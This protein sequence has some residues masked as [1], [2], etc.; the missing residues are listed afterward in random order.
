MTSLLLF[1]AAGTLALRM[2]GPALSV[3]PVQ[4]S[5]LLM[6]ESPVEDLTTLKARRKELKP[7]LEAKEAEGANFLQMKM[8]LT[9][10]NERNDATLAEV[11]TSGWLGWRWG[12]GV[13]RWSASSALCH[14]TIAPS[15]MALTCRRRRRSPSCWPRSARCGRSVRRWRRASTWRRPAQRRA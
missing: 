7:M 1:T 13:A 14:R 2:P 15:A 11:R 6:A 8:K 3:R 9:A 10:D 5:A 4:R 12:G